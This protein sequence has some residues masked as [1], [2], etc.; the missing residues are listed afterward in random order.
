MSTRMSS[1][2]DFSFQN[3]TLTKQP[4]Q[5]AFYPEKIP[6]TS[7]DALQSKFYNNSAY[8]EQAQMSSNNTVQ[9]NSYG[10]YEDIVSQNKH[11]DSY[12]ERPLQNRFYDD[13]GFSQTCRNTSNT[14][15][16]TLLQVSPYKFADRYGYN[17]VPPINL[18]DKYTVPCD[19]ALRS[20]SC[21]PSWNPHSIHE[22]SHTSPYNMYPDQIN[23]KNIPKSSPYNS[24]TEQHSL[25]NVSQAPPYNQRTRSN[26]YK[27]RADKSSFSNALQNN[28][29]NVFQ[30]NTPRTD[31]Y[32]VHFDQRDVYNSTEYNAGTSFKDDYQMDVNSNTN[33]NQ[34]NSTRGQSTHT[35]SYNACVNQTNANNGLRINL[36]SNYYADYFKGDSTV[37]NINT[38]P[39]NNFNRSYSES[40]STPPTQKLR[41]NSYDSYAVP[42]NIAVTHPSSQNST[43]AHQHRSSTTP[44]KTARPQNEFLRQKWADRHLNV[45]D[46]D[47]DNQSNQRYVVM[48]QIIPKKSYSDSKKPEKILQ[49]QQVCAKKLK[50]ASNDIPA[51]A[52]A[53][54]KCQST[55]QR[56]GKVH[57]KSK[58]VRKIEKLSHALISGQDVMLSRHIIN[59]N[60]LVE[61]M[62]GACLKKRGRPIKKISVH[63]MKCTRKPFRN[64]G[65]ACTKIS[66]KCG[67]RSSEKA[68]IKI[69]MK[70][71][72]IAVDMYSWADD[73]SLEEVNNAERSPSSLFLR[74]KSRDVFENS[75]G[76]I[77]EEEFGESQWLRSGFYEKINDPKA[78]WK[79]LMLEPIFPNLIYQ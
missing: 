67:E 17:H 31:L 46:S 15:H 19:N 35:T 62:E 7:N 36:S 68:T 49:P 57:K 26:V 52:T 38:T 72:V 77:R 16:N 25:T 22:V 47:L 42:F 63:L 55:P 4:I 78:A 3:H 10:M 69:K 13:P 30:E 76:I 27:I 24:Y 43:K 51:V 41:E 70:I 2:N 56:L 75:S 39:Q 59:D 54:S 12:R 23:C 44:L 45:L 79:I 1:A 50:K 21:N 18:Y 34:Y 11:C 14:K 5:T 73:F 37:S 28:Y 71:G 65:K 64:A 74:P 66:S 9:N 61:E 6:I 8:A 32:N 53:K 33:T 58:V 29:Y 20:K 60:E 48:R 40:C